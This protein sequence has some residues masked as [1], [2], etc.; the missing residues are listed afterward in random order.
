[1]P[2]EDNIFGFGELEGRALLLSHT[3]LCKRVWVA[4]KPYSNKGTLSLVGYFTR[5]P[6]TKE[7]RERERVKATS[8]LPRGVPVHLS[9]YYSL[10]K[11]KRTKN[12]I[13]P[14]LPL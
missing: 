8:G 14:L 9:I 6:I 12:T 3:M 4:Q 5:E 7:K 11:P 10:Q 2:E 13:V 1:M